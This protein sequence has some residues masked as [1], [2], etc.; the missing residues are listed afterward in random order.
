LQAFLT[1]CVKRMLLLAC[2]RKRC[3]HPEWARLGD[4]S[5]L[6]CVTL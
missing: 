1:S 2:G 6:L 3:S 5:R 4:A